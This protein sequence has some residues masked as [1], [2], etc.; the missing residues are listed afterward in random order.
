MRYF[1]LAVLLFSCYA[2]VNADPVTIIGDAFALHYKN[3]TGKIEDFLK[4]NLNE[5]PDIVA[6]QIFSD[7]PNGF[8]DI[9]VFLQG[10]AGTLFRSEWIYDGQLL[11]IDDYILPFDF[12]PDFATGTAHLFPLSY[13][14]KPV[15]LNLTFGGQTAT[16][17]F[18]VREPIPEPATIGLFSLGSIAF[19]CYMRR[20]GKKSSRKKKLDS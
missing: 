10:P 19:G 5:H 20:T 9:L 11:G 2:T 15:V 6:Q 16:Y 4:T 14:A 1:W 18:T 8:V 7:N 17:T 3:G 12:G 13:T